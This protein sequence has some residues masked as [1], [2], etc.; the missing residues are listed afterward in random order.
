M[1]AAKPADPRAF[2][3][4]QIGE[5]VNTHAS[6]V[7]LGDIIMAEG[8]DFKLIPHRYYCIVLLGPSQLFQVTDT[9]AATASV[10]GKEHVEKQVRQFISQHLFNSC[11]VIQ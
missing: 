6:D 10:V 5:F 11:G 7:Q 1:S 2:G 4:M 8:P 3:N 9:C